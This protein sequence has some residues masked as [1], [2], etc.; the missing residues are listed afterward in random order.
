MCGAAAK[1]ISVRLCDVSQNGL[2]TR[3]F[4]LHYLFFIPLLFSTSNA[5][6]FIQSVWS[7]EVI[8]INDR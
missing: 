8:A 3:W 2:K 6:E 7:V 4:A 5:C 1:S